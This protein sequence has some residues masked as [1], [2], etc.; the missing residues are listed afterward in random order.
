VSQSP[1]FDGIKQVANICTS[2][3]FPRR[4]KHKPMTNVC[5]IRWGMRIKAALQCKGYVLINELWSS[6][7]LC[8][9]VIYEL[10][11]FYDANSNL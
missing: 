4:G 11:S 3:P 2:A 10:R 1:T 9:H 7:S 8:C 5:Q 6:S